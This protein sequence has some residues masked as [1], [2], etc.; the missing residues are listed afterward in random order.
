[1]REWALD[2][3]YAVSRYP[4]AL[5]F[6]KV[7]WGSFP[8]TEEGM[9]QEI[10]F[11]ELQKNGFRRTVW[12]LVFPEQS[13]GL[14]KKIPLQ[15]DGTNEYHVRFYSDGIIHCESEVHRFSPHHFSGVRHHDGTRVLEKILYEEMEL[16]L[17]IKDKIRKLFGIK[18]YA[19][20]CVRK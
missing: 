9:Y 11:K 4:S 17:T 16:H 7:V 12:Q 15:E 18:D 1:M 5:F 14:I 3:H 19:E 10:F 2:L 13:A 6:P 8:K 20:H